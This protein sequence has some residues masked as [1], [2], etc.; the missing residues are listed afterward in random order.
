MKLS[1]IIVSW[2]VKDKLRENLKAL[3]DSKVDFKY[4]IIVVDNNSED[5]TVAMVKKEFSKVH[6]LVNDINL[7]LSKAWNIALKQINGKY[8]LVFNPDMVVREDTLQKMYDWME[9]NKQANVAGCKLVDEKGRLVKH[10]RCF[11]DFVNQLAIVLKLPHIFKNILNKYLR[12]DFDYSRAAQADSIRG[13]F[14]MINMKSVREL[15]L[16]RN[17]T[18][19]YFD[20]RYF[21]WFE[22]VDYCKQIKKAGGEVWYTPVA[23]CV[24]L[25]GAS[26]KQ[27]PRGVTQRYMQ[28]SQLKYFKKWHPAWQW[29]IL[30]LAWPIGKFMAIIG[31]KVGLKSKAKT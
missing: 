27:V 9:N 18:L 1:I 14:F 21:L 25:V 31:E 30:R 13:S 4:E 11:P 10:V 29:F 5:N 22:E 19:P 15:K 26:F 23:E 7:G 8:A 12:N 17:S 16:F 6:L 2:N 3:L 20:E 28:D 24:D